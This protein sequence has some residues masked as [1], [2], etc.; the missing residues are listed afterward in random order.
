MFELYD[1]FDFQLLVAMLLP[2]G[3]P[4]EIAMNLE[5]M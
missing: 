1:K 4:G 5:I 2:R 3:L